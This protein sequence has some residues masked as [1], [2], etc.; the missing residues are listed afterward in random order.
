MPEQTTLQTEEV[1]PIESRRDVLADAFE[2]AETPQADTQEQREQRARDEAGR[3]A[4]K[5]PEAAQQPQAAQPAVAQPPAV[6]EKRVLKTW[7]AEYRSLHDKMEA[8]LPLTPDEAKRVAEYNYQRESEYATGVS[9]YKDRAQ[10]L[11]AVDKAIAPFMPA[12]QKH[13]IA[14]DQW[15]SNLGRAHETLALGTPQ[16]KLQMF[17]TLAQQYGIPLGAVQQAQGGGQIDPT[18]LSL[19]ER[20]DQLSGTVKD[21]AG[22]REQQ[23]QS[24]VTS[25]IAALETDAEKYPWFAEA[26][27]LMAQLLELGL[28]ENLD[29]AY[30][31]A[32]RMDEALW[33]K[34]QARQSQASQAHSTQRQVVAKAKAAAV[35]PRSVTP[36]GSVGM[37]AAQKD[38]RAVISEAFETHGGRV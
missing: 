1:E 29:G 26:K 2:Q 25:E 33:T 32:V 14:P 13:N 21:V 8:G 9:V 5:E 12:L 35:S 18:V 11:E 4:R 37:N 38:R 15:I 16:Q 22:W 27:P 10:R 6:P 19:M 34:E 24:R 36:S 23:E 20:I 7:K 30:T 28:A 3:F 31:K 17:Q